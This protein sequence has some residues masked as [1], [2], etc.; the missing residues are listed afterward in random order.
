MKI[1]AGYAA[2]NKKTYSIM[3][4]DATFVD[5][6]ANYYRLC[7]PIFGRYGTSNMIIKK[8]DLDVV[9][10][11]WNDEDEDRFVISFDKEKVEKF[12][13]Q[14]F[15]EKMNEYKELEAAGIRRYTYEGE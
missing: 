12:V 8:T 9:T 13:N 7:K 10:P 2:P 14:K 15:T 6:D 5:D 11:Y 3:E 1:Y 4:V